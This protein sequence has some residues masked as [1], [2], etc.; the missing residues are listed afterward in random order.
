MEIATELAAVGGRI[1]SVRLQQ[2][3][4]LA[5]LARVTG[6]S[7][8]TLSRLETG[9]RKPTLELLLRVARGIGVP[10]DDLVT[11]RGSRETGRMPLTRRAG[12]LKAYKRVIPPNDP[13]AR[14][15][16]RVHAGFEWF[17]VLSGR[18]ALRLGESEV[19]IEQGEVAEFD[20]RLP[21][22]VRNPGPG[23]AEIIELHGPRGERPRVRAATVVR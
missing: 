9:G 3:M 6:I 21:H 11:D 16:A 2:R 10:L 19:M 4:T 22:L 8:S 17:Y 12:T 13:D 20:T 1:R 23:Y 7:I 5:D 15:S 18:I 14:P